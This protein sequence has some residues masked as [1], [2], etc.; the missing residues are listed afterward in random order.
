MKK[1]LN[2]ATNFIE[3]YVGTRRA[4]SEQSD[5][6]IYNVFGQTLSFVR[7]GLEPAPTVKMDVSVIEPGMYFVRTGDRV[8]K[9]VK[10]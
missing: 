1:A 5:V 4:V 7:A 10:M 8:G 3:L 9:F 2:P 6:K